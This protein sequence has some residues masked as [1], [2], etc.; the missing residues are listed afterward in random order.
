[1]DNPADKN[2]IESVIQIIEEEQEGEGKRQKSKYDESSF[3]EE[4]NDTV[5]ELAS[6]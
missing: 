1:M 4:D 5:G 6:M 3:D 2:V